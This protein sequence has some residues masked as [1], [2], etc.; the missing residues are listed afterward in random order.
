MAQQTYKG[1]VLQRIAGLSFIVGAILLVVFNILFPRA[2]DPA[3]AGAFVQKVAD[4]RGGLWE[5]VNLMLA[6]GIWAFMIGAAGVYRSI[7]TGG[8]AVWA[9][10]GFYGIIVGTTLWTAL[11]ALNGFGLP[12]IV[13]QWG[14]ASG[15]TKDTLSVVASSVVNL[16]NGLF[17]MS[18]IVNW[19][20]LSFLG[21]GMTLSS[22]YPKWLGWVI[23]ALG[24]LTV[25]LVGIPQGFTGPSKT[26]SNLIFPILSI[27]S[28]VWALIL[29]IWIT[30]R[31]I[32][33]M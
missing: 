30:R 22:V 23:L 1:D 26:V 20:A 19:L 27:L 5:L 10:L 11:F 21:I 18:V 24:V 9:R 31:E 3:D 15:A 25:V 8:A 29:G 2:S 7:T 17:T 14:S 33:A 4:N 28:T 13:E 16:T 6:I 32:K 12:L